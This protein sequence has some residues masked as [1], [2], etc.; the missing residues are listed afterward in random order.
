MDE[1]GNVWNGNA[2]MAYGVSW[3]E[4][5]S[6]VTLRLDTAKHVSGR[7][8]RGGGGGKSVDEMTASGATEMTAYIC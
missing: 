7:E 3:T 2:F 8:R 6:I 1:N 4:R 5:N